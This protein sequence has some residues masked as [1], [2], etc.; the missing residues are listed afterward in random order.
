MVHLYNNADGEGGIY[1]VIC[2]SSWKKK[3]IVIYELSRHTSKGK[4]L[5]NYIICLMCKQNIIYK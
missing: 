4:S 3:I 5:N 2:N 1:S